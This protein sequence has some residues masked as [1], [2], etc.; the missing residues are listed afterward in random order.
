MSSD[1]GSQENSAP[2]ACRVCGAEVPD[3]QLICAVCGT[4]Y[5]DPRGPIFRMRRGPLVKAAAI[6]ILLALA[7]SMIAA[8]VF[9]LR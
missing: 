3:G 9:A 5:R 2:A 8:L 7:A 6:V 1:S 4:D